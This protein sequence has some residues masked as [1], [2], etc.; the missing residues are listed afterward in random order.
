MD[1]TVF[2]SVLTRNHGKFLPHY[3]RSL[4]DMDYDKKNI[5]IYINTNNNDDD[6]MGFLTSWI[7]QNYFKYRNIIFEK[8]IDDPK[9]TKDLYWDHDNNRRLKKMASIRN[10]SLDICRLEK[11]DYYF[12]MDTDNWVAP[13]TLKYLIQKEKPIIAPFIKLHNDGSM[14]SN[15]FNEV[16]ETGY[17]KP[18]PLDVDMWRRES[19]VGTFKVPL[20]HCTY[21]IDTKYINDVSYTS[22]YWGDHHYEFVLFANNAREKNVDQYICNE[23]MF[24][25]VNYGNIIDESNCYDL[26]L[27]KYYSDNKIDILNIDTHLGI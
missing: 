8:G 3:F 7:G 5:V 6:T 20:V 25:F 18:S 9:I 16:T 24:G 22:S 4:E 23:K 13:I 27:K 1:K 2:I 26:L 15:Y 12:V 17:Y 14:Y 21:L 10:R 19:M 11:T